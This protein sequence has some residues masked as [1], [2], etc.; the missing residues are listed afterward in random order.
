VKALRLYKK[1]Q[2]ICSHRLACKWCAFPAGGFTFW[3]RSHRAVHRFFR[4]RPELID[5]SFYVLPEWGDGAWSIMYDREEYNYGLDVGGA[6]EFI[7]RKGDGKFPKDPRHLGS[8]T[9]SLV[10]PPA[11]RSVWRYR[12]DLLIFLQ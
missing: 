11:C 8:L 4:K 9:P 7:G 1:Q 6:T 10:S 12:F 2:A 5:G 3:P